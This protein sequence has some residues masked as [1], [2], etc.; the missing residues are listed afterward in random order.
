MLVVSVDGVE[1]PEEGVEPAGHWKMC[2]TT[3]V[4]LDI[5]H[6]PAP[7]G[8]HSREDQ[9]LR[10]FLMQVWHLPHPCR[11]SIHR[12]VDTRLTAHTDTP[13]RRT[14]VAW[15]DPMLPAK[16]GENCLNFLVDTGATGTDGLTVT[17]PD[18]S[19]LA[20][21]QM[22]QHGQYLLQPVAEE[23]AATGDC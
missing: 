3:A 5:G 2:A 6:A 8:D 10:S 23:Y 17:F 16:V 20:F 4:S 13:L 9:D 18:G 14:K 15:A 19:S 11:A 1:H 12:W 22:L 7:T 21:E